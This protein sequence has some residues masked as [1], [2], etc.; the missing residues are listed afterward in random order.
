[1]S[2]PFTNN[3]YILDVVSVINFVLN[4]EVPSDTQFASSDVNSDG[5]I[6]VLDV[7]IIVNIVLEG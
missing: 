3:L 7:V 6:N 5:L 2:S 4:N 1:M